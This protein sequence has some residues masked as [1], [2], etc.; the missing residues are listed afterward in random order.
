[1][2]P[3]AAALSGTDGAGSSYRCGK[4]AYGLSV[5]DDL[6]IRGLTI[7]VQKCYDLA[8][9]RLHL[10]SSGKLIRYR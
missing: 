4:A 9:P 5:L 7:R 2:A 1:M 10:P 6:T 3:G 8:H